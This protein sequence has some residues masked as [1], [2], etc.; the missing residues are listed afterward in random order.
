MRR[1]ARPATGEQD[2]QVRFPIRLS[3]AATGRRSQ[4][5]TNTRP[6]LESGKTPSPSGI[7]AR[8]AGDRPGLGSGKTPSPPR[9]PREAGR[10]P[11]PGQE[12]NDATDLRDELRVGAQLPR[13]DDVRLEAEGPSAMSHPCSAGGS[14]WP[15][16]AFRPMDISCAS[17]NGI[18]AIYP[19]ANTK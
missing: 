16:E 15:H 12:A 5:A 17:D 7:R 2:E 9:N 4:Q 10:R 11:A 18:T 13:L 19:A 3:G 6:G 1:P 8:P 14:S